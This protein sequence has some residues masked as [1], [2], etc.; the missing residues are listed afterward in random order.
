MTVHLP[1]LHDLNRAGHAALVRELGVA[2]ALRF[3]RQFTTG[4]GDYTANRDATTGEESVETLFARVQAAD[5]TRA[6]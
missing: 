1:T 3:L 6:R 5:R 2:G 4:E